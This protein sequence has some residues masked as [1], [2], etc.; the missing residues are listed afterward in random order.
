MN[1][2]M[3]QLWFHPAPDGALDLPNV[4]LWEEIV[5]CE[6]IF[7]AVAKALKGCRTQISLPDITSIGIENHLMSGYAN[8]YEGK[9]V[10]TVEYF[11]PLGSPFEFWPVYQRHQ[12][13]LAQQLLSWAESNIGDAVMALTAIDEIARNGGS[14]FR[15]LVADIRKFINSKIEQ[16]ALSEVSEKSGQSSKSRPL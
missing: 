13:E 9:P 2:M 14:D 3:I 15:L 7:D 10:F 5:F 8:F 4:V 1:P 11:D 6:D 16:E 12:E